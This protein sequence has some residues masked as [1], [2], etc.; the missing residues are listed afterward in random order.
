ME[1]EPNPWG[2]I[3]KPGTQPIDLIDS[4]LTEYKHR[5]M[6]T[7]RETRDVLLDIRSAL[8]S[9]G[10]AN[11]SLQ[12]QP[13]TPDRADTDDSELAHSGSVVETVS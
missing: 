10:G 3:P 4:F 11:G 2:F 9:T 8:T 5:E 6:F 12:E 13:D 1:H 7:G